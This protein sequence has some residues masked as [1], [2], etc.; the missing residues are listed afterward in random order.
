[1]KPATQQTLLSRQSETLLR[2]ALLRA[3]RD[4]AT[5]QDRIDCAELAQATGDDALARLLYDVV[6]VRLG[7]GPRELEMQAAIMHAAGFPTYS[8]DV[9]PVPIV[10]GGAST[11]DLAMADLQALVSARQQEHAPPPPDIVEETGTSFDSQLGALVLALRNGPANA[12]TR[13]PLRVAHFWKSILA[14]TPV[15]PL[16]DVGADP[17][18]LGRTLARFDLH[19]LFAPFHDLAA[20]LRGSPALLHA[21]ASLSR[22]GLGAWFSNVDNIIRNGGDLLAMLAMLTP[23]DSWTSETRLL[24]LA[25]M[26]AN[27][28]EARLIEV[29]DVL[30][31]LGAAQALDR[32]F[33]AGSHRRHSYIVAQRF[34]DTALDLQHWPLAIAA[35]EQAM[36]AANHNPGELRVL[37]DIVASS[38]DFRYARELLLR[39]SGLQSDDAG[40]AYRL[41]A[42]DAEDY[43]PFLI[44]AGLSNEAFRRHMRRVARE[45][46]ADGRAEMAEA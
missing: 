11:I 26:T 43:S 18:T 46:A 32:L 6:F 25:P 3:A 35:Q 17:A 37:A 1:M 20:D 44:S 30:G 31:D 45:R 10:P 15:D 7:F 27:L 29:V 41:R 14:I 38:G 16:D 8:A 39:Y 42:V 9:R 5:L 22:E 33:A 4:D 13:L 34:R 12:S 23:G 2:V 28:S 40:T 24:W 21:L 36:R 19:R